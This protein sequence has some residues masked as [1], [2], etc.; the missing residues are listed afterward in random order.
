LLSA[1]LIGTNLFAYCYNNPAMNS[2]PT[3]YGILP[4]GGF[5]SF[6]KNY[7]SA[8]SA[9]AKKYAPKSD[10]VEYGA[11]IYK[12]R[13]MWKSYYFMGE[14]YKGFETQNWYT[15]INGLG[16]GYLV[17]R[18]TKRAV[19]FFW[20]ISSLTMIG[21]AHTHPLQPGHTNQPSGPD[22]W[23]KRG[24]FFANMR[25]FPIAIYRNKKVSINYF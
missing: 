16:A 18:A 22:V 8:V 14:T 13:V 20:P 24:G 17:G 1:N 19:N 15:V 11:I 5:G 23:M 12:I 9:W 3:G 7:K 4:V 6:Y 10:G 25:I 2:Y 21:F